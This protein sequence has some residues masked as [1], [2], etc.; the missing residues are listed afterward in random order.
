L[1][2]DARRGGFVG[3]LLGALLLASPPAARAQIDHVILVSVDGLRSDAVTV[4][5]PAKLPNFYRLR[6]QGSYTDNARTDF[7]FTSTLPNHTSM[8]TGRGVLGP[9]GH[10]WTIN[11]DSVITIHQNKGSY[12]PSVLDLVHDHGLRTGV[13]ATKTKFDVYDRS[14]DA[15]N[16]ALD[17]TGPD[18]GRDKLDVYF[19]G[20]DSATVVASYLA[21]MSAAPFHFS[22]IHLH[23]PDTAGH[24]F[25]WSLTAGSAYLDS[26]VAVDALIGQIFLLI[27]TD[28]RFTG[29]T[30]VILTADHGGKL[31]TYSHGDEDDPENYTI[32]LYVWGPGVIPGAE[33]YS[34]NPGSRFDPGNTRPDYDAPL[35][36][37]RNGDAANLALDALLLP[38]IAGSSLNLHFE[39]RTFFPSSAFFTITSTSGANE[40]EWINLP[41]SALRTAL[42]RFKTDGYPAH[43]QDG[44]LLLDDAV[45]PGRKNEFVH[46]NLLNDTTYYYRLFFKD[47]QDQNLGSLSLSGQP[48]DT[49]GRVKWA[50]QTGAASLAPPGIGSVYAVSN[51]RGIHSIQGGPEGGGWPESWAPFGMLAPAQHRPAVAPVNVRGASKVLLLGSQDGSVYL[52]DG[53]SGRPV[54]RSARLGD[55]V[56]AAPAAMFRRFGGQYDLILV[57]TRNSGGGPDNVFYGLNLAD[58]SIAWS[59][60]NGGGASG[61]GIISGGATVDYSSNRVY[62]ASRAGGSPSTLWCL[63]FAVAQATPCWPGGLPLGNIEGSPVLHN[64]KVFVGTNQSE[65]YAVR[66]DPDAADDGK[67]LWSVNAGDGPVKGFIWTDRL[68]NRLFFS[69]TGRVSALAYD[70][71]SAAFLWSS[72]AIPAPSVPLFTP[73]GHHLLIGGSDGYLY[74]LDV[75]DA[76]APSSRVRLGDGSAGIG[77]PSLDVPFAMVYVGSEAGA[78]FSVQLPLPPP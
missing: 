67:I 50:F 2:A 75:N 15:V 63:E 66:A 44:S 53:R 29:R 22:M 49:S 31:G 9:A 58:G 42:L 51:D 39:L 47:A 45:L 35:Q 76:A 16:G 69:T 23:D 11:K 57:G 48:L 46:S 12:V 18:D 54:W 65:V 62:F 27:D 59:F 33:L 36:P 40:L 37:I 13:Y 14:Y 64:G 60:D 55:S 6:Q 3:A 25:S 70:D 61:I 4:Q 5:G 17:V 71:S 34:L 21:A 30:F 68:S 72:A 74:Q 19:Y 38:A 20:S 77:S 1:R 7:D 43:D 24:S 28:S 52:V 73:G 41:S 78:V 26:I 10:Q 32:P 8:L 56:Q